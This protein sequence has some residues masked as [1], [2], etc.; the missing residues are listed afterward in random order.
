MN[1]RKTPAAQDQADAVV[2]LL[3]DAVDALAPAVRAGDPRA[4]DALLRVL[5]AK[6]RH[7]PPPP[8]EADRQ[9]TVRGIL[10]R[11]AAYPCEPDPE[12]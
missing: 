11:M 5:E 12:S 6:S 8:E 2:E 10:H 3:D 7:Q 1:N 9:R 4:V